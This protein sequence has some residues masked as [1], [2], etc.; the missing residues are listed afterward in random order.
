MK[1]QNGGAHTLSSSSSFAKSSVF[2]GF[3]C[4]QPCSVFHILHKLHTYPDLTLRGL[5]R[6]LCLLARNRLPII[7]SPSSRI[8]P[9]GGC[10]ARLPRVL[11]SSALLLPPGLV[12]ALS[13]WTAPILSSAQTGTTRSYIAAL[14]C[15]KRFSSPSS[16]DVEGLTTLSPPH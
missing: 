3:H 10:E 13:H 4:F 7:L 16:F 6:K 14:R 8:P 12:D 2:E 11:L 9:I 5:Y 1:V 15:D